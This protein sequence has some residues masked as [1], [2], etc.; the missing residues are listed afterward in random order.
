MRARLFMAGPYDAMTVAHI[1][2]HF[3]E[4]LQ[5]DITFS[6]KRDDSLIGGFIAAVD[7]RLYDSSIR[8]RVER[9]QQHLFTR[10]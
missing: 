1:T 7:G 8:T 6:V 4:L 2:S 5:R 3:R 10:K 9:M